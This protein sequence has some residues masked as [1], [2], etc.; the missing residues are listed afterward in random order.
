MGEIT[1]ICYTPEAK[2]GRQTGYRRIST[3]RANLLVNYGIEGDRKGGSR[4]RQLNVMSAETLQ[5]LAAQGF[6]TAPGQ[7]G[8]Q[9]I[10]SGIDVDTLQPGD[11]LQL[12]D[13]VIE[14]TVP[15]E[16]CGKFVRYQGQD[17]AGVPLGMMAKV[18]TGGVIAVGDSALVVRAS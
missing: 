16:G 14:V 12:G 13:A 8:E 17:P 18:I 10:V 11:R 4:K 3:K 5:V 2:Q 9:V 7:M 1:S 6:N 15:R